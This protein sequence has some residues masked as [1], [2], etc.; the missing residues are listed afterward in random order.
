MANPI[1]NIEACEQQPAPPNFQAWTLEQFL[2]ADI[3]ERKLLLG[4]WLP[5][6]GSAMIHGKAGVGKTQFALSVAMAV[7]T[8]QP[9]LGWCVQQP[10][11]V[12][13]ID[14]EMNPSDMQ[15]RLAARYMSES[16]DT[17]NRLEIIS[18]SIQELRGEIF[19]LARVWKLPSV[20]PRSFPRQLSSIARLDTIFQQ[21]IPDCIHSFLG[22]EWHRDKHF[23][24]FRL[25]RVLPLMLPL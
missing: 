16:S 3:P 2:A 12:L 21:G 5:V 10:A 8:G 20:A 22:F 11:R 17:D 4:P 18:D 23:P 7:A 13:Y 14:G 19:N 25:Q 6:G 24:P 9:F 1:A 15:A